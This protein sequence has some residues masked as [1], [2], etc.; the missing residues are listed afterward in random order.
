MNVAHWLRLVAFALLTGV[1]AAAEL[2]DW[3]FV[4]SVGGLKVG[5]AR[6][7]QDGRVLLPIHCDVSGLRAITRRPTTLNSGLRCLPP[8]V[9]VRTGES[10]IYL[11]IRTGPATGGAKASSP[12]ADLGQAMPGEYAL[13]YRDPNGRSRRLRQITVPQG[14]CLAAR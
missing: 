7:L 1:G 12:P 8:R 10:I 6:R 5:P 3:K 11:T 14:I 2:R 9:E 13:R 4:Q